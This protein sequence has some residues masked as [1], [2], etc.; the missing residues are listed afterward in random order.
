M[1]ISPLTTLPA[2]DPAMILRCRD[3]QYAAELIAVA[4]LHFDFFT[5]L[6]GHPGVDT[7]T[8]FSHFGFAPRP[9]DVLLTLCRAHGFLATDE[10]GGHRLTPLAQEHLVK[11]SPW[12]LGPYY[13]PIR[14]TPVVQGFLQVMRTGKPANWQA[15]AG[16]EDWHRGP[17]AEAVDRLVALPG[18]G[19]VAAGGRGEGL[20]LAGGLDG[21]AARQGSRRSGRVKDRGTRPEPKPLPRRTKPRC[22]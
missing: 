11:G 2:T 5:W 12:F 21:A 14:D 4:L 1:M 6:E 16:A 8:V 7:A 19:R 9:A 3:R 22:R 18:A 17:G 13:E 20:A 10:T 15:K